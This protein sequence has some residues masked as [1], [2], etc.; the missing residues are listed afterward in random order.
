MR[1][2]GWM[3]VWG[4]RPQPVLPPAHHPTPLRPLGHAQ[5]PALLG[6]ADL[7]L[8]DA[9]QLHTV[10][11]TH[12]LDACSAPTQPTAARTR[13]HTFACLCGHGT[14]YDTYPLQ[15]AMGNRQHCYG[16]RMEAGDRQA[17]RQAGGDRQDW[18]GRPR[19][20]RPMSGG[21]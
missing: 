7:A 10:H 1:V 12:C 13:R 16:Q 2:G 19:A 9:R 20:C 17:R 21:R 15:V 18:R 11:A 5:L 6:E 14:L 4:G 3:G 8:L